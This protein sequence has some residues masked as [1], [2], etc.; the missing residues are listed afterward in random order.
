MA[1]RECGGWVGRCDRVDESA[2]GGTTTVA[3]SDSAGAADIKRDAVST[4]EQG[5]CSTAITTVVRR[6][7]RVLEGLVDIHLACIR[8]EFSCTVHRLYGM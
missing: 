3:R 6:C 4:A 8:L 2:K 1:T 5:G 7:Y